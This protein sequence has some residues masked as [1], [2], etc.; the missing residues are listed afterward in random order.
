ML[1]PLMELQARPCSGI[2]VS[3]NVRI[4]TLLLGR[5]DDVALERLVAPSPKP[6][7]HRPDTLWP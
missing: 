6:Q 4:I 1:V 7:T 5:V 3:V 2:S